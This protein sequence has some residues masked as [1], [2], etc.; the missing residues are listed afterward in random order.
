[1]A[2]V[3]GAVDL[4]SCGLML[5]ATMCAVAL[6]LWHLNTPRMLAVPLNVPVV[7]MAS[8]ATARTALCVVGFGL[9]V[10]ATGSPGLLLGVFMFSRWLMAML[11]LAMLVAMHRAQ[12]KVA[13][14]QGTMGLLFA[15]LSM[16]AA[17]ELRAQLVSAHL[18]YSL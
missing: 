11:G 4:A 16:V 10:V 7:L 14:S 13:E 8:A 12:S 1:M 17:G 9:A 6:C 3:L 5:G 15:G 2:L 18:L